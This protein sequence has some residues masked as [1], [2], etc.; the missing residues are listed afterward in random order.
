VTGTQIWS[1]VGEISALAMIQWKDVQYNDQKNMIYKTL[2][3]NLN[4]DPQE[5]QK[6]MVLRNGKQFLLHY[7]HLLKVEIIMNKK[8]QIHWPMFR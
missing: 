3:R 7:W 6:N 8:S 2:D 4:I 5:Q 1:L